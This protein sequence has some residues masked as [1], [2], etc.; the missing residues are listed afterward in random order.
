M[1]S[2]LLQLLGLPARHSQAMRSG[3]KIQLTD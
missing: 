2:L 3:C 1:R